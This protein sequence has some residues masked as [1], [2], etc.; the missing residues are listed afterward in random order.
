MNVRA[1]SRVLVRTEDGK[2][3]AL[4]KFN[5]SLVERACPRLAF[6]LLEGNAIY[7]KQEYIGPLDA[8]LNFLH[9]R[10][11]PCGSSALLIETYKLAVIF[12]LDSLCEET[13]GLLKLISSSEKL[14]L[15]DFLINC[16]NSAK[17]L[18]LSDTLLRAV[19]QDAFNALQSP[20]W[21][22]VSENT[23]LLRASIRPFRHT[24]LRI[25]PVVCCD[26][27]GKKTGRQVVRKPEELATY[28]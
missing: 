15:F 2:N 4:L 6:Y 3:A 16:K 7:L 17:H 24:C 11:V 25:I 26:R 19:V 28:A 20:A 12:E 21:L 14:E 8:I 18:E 22:N 5:K 13:E 27:V 10:Q 9:S 23:V 1:D